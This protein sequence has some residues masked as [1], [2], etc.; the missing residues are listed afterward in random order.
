MMTSQMNKAVSGSLNHLTKQRK[1]SVHRGEFLHSFAFIHDTHNVRTLLCQVLE[2]L[3]DKLL[4]RIEYTLLEQSLS[5]NSNEKAAR[6][7]IEKEIKKS[8][9]R[10]VAHT[11]LVKMIYFDD[12][13]VAII[14]KADR[15]DVPRH[16]FYNLCKNLS[17]ETVEQI[18]AYQATESVYDLAALKR[19]T[20]AK[21]WRYSLP[22]TK[23]EI[24]SHTA[25]F[26]LSTKD[27]SLILLA[28]ARV[29]SVLNDTS[30]IALPVLFD[31]IETQNELGWSLL[32]I[33]MSE[34]NKINTSLEAI[35]SMLAAPKKIDSQCL[36]ELKESWGD[37][38][39]FP[40]ALVLNHVE[41]DT[42]KAISFANNS[43]VTD[44]QLFP[45]LI[46]CQPLIDGS[47][48]ISIN[49]QSN[50]FCHLQAEQLGNMTK[51]VIEAMRSELV[52][53]NGELAI[54]S[55]EEVIAIK[56]SGEQGSTAKALY[57]GRIEER[58]RELV[59][60]QPHSEAIA[61]GD[62]MLTYQQLDILATKLAAYLVKLG[63]KE[64]DHVGLCLTR[65]INMIPAA[66]AV[67]KAGAVYV[68]IDPNYPQDR[69]QF[70]CEDAAL[71]LLVCESTGIDA[72]V[73]ELELTTWYH[74]SQAYDDSHFLSPCFSA[75]APAYMIYT[76]G[77]TG[78]PKGTLIPHENVQYLVGAVQKPFALTN[79]DVWSM[80]HSFSF[81]FSI[82]E[83]WGALLTGAK[84]CII[85]YDESRDTKAF[86]DVL[87][88]QKVTILSQTPSAFNQLIMVEEN[89]HL[90]DSIRLVIFGGESLDTEKLLPWFD[91]HP[92]SAC[93]LINM[94]G[95]TETTVHVTAH[96]VDRQSALQRSK[97]VGKAIDG[98][99]IYVLDK[100][101]KILPYGVPGEIYVSGNGVATGYFNREQLN[102]ERFIDNPFG[103][104]KLYSSGD[105]GCLLENG[106]LE[107]LGRLDSQV[108]IRGF[109]IELDE[110]K[111]Q[112]LTCEIVSQASVLVKNAV[113]GDAD[114]AQIIAYV[115]CHC[116]DLSLLW[117]SLLNS[118]PDFMLPSMIHRVS[119]MPLTNNGKLNQKSLEDH[120]V[121]SSSSVHLKHQQVIIDVDLDNEHLSEFQSK[122]KGI[123]QSLFNKDIDLDDNFFDL[124]GNSLY[125]IQMAKKM[126]E[127][128]MPEVSL[129]ELYSHQTIANISR[130]LTV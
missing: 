4:T 62:E 38:E 18:K 13:K 110:I 54:L 127:L 117:K 3:S 65:N 61:M 69:I 72:R 112:L 55:D 39:D 90:G 50:S 31:Q 70:T 101:Q 118:L 16:V 60:Q 71:N 115:V 88:K 75:Q 86:I 21:P 99:N 130:I 97:S 83:I 123:W 12:S 111:H 73:N 46:D 33:D 25:S 104:G 121:S 41:L 53:S 11:L 93:Q 47:T 6:K 80:F 68:P 57:N 124:G 76:S 113:A 24:D 84:V 89:H 29:L 92:E 119:H 56:Q 108:K 66:L 67:M 48:V 125:A 5:L 35:K 85:S 126:R 106:E 28:F 36:E 78:K 34:Q 15:R 79:Q 27:T 94:F 96:H 44:S 100:G 87:N 43:S 64:G 122:L 107:H 105:K 109:R 129:K 77:S 59:I 19:A 45:I 1:S 32:P 22:K 20:I 58:I 82:W 40:I 95:I 91:R 9:Q 74:K 7:R 2:A 10:H 81:D 14:L 103:D 114:S 49:Y 42:R 63:I 26:S 51:N 52:S 98:W 102:N 8:D 37:V 17:G 120:I 23:L 30:Q 116:D 128:G